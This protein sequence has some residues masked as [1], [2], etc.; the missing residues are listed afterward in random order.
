MAKTY[1]GGYVMLDLAD[2]KLYDR[3]KASIGSGKP[4]MVYDTDNAVYY[5]DS[6][7][8]DGTDVIITKGGK[9]ITIASDGTITSS[10]DIQNHLWLH[11]II[12]SFEYNG[13]AQYVYGN[14]LT[15]NNDILTLDDLVDKKYLFTYS[16]RN[17]SSLD[18]CGMCSIDGNESVGCEFNLNVGDNTIEP[19]ATPLIMEYTPKQIF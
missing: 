17:V 12:L 7:A 6:I 8:L 1:N 16:T 19:D 4:V 14:V 5:I 2:P 11:T 9:T 10:G 15:D 13:D 3:A 18:G